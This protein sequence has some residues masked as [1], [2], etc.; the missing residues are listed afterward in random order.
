MKAYKESDHNERITA[1]HDAKK[2]REYLL[3]GK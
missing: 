1:F 3:T 2:A